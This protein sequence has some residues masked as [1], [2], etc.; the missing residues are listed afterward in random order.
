MELKYFKI[1]AISA[2]ERDYLFPSLRIIRIAE[3]SAD[4]QIGK[5][6]VCC[7]KGDILLLNNLTARR[8]VQI[9][10]TPFIVEVFEFP[11][12][13]VHNFTKLTSHFY[14]QNAIRF[15]N[16]TTVNSALDIIAANFCCLQNDL[17]FEHQ[18]M[19][20]FCLLEDLCPNTSHS[21]KSIGFIAA[22]YIWDNY[23]ND[24]TVSSISQSL[25]VSKSHL[26]NVF[27]KVHN[28]SVGEYLRHIRIYHIT[29][30]LKAQ[31]RRSVLDIA[32]SNGFK[33]AS[34]FYKAFKAIT[35]HTPKDII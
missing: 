6:T 12:D 23:R 32:F 14:S 20:V 21:A 25:N 31:P 33:S 35:G 27:K 8:I 17:F 9:F 29:N 13:S 10:N 34:G 26:E 5:T 4:W 7:D 24:I 11:P 3:G 1:T 2:S 18:L 28:I 19:S 15:R 16:Q 22:K 30:E